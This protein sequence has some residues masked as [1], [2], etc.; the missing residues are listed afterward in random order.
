MEVFSKVVEWVYS[1]AVEILAILGGLHAVA[2]FTPWEADNKIVD[3]LL[4]VFKR[5]GLQPRPN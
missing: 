5:I 4:K 1:H 3:F 2:K